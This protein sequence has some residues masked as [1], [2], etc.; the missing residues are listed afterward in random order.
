MLRKRLRIKQLTIGDSQQVRRTPRCRSGGCHMK[1]VLITILMCV[2]VFCYPSWGGQNE[3][4]D[5]AGGLL[6]ILLDVVTAPCS[7]LA[8][9]IGQDAGPCA[10][11]SDQKMQCTPLRE[12]RHHPCVNPA[13]RRS[14]SPVSASKASSVSRS[15]PEKSL[16]SSGTF[17]T[18]KIYPSCKSAC[19]RDNQ[20]SRA[21]KGN[22]CP[23]RS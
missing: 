13:T 22:I 19:C 11:Q 6:D 8:V 10:Y 23:H 20:I 9:C 12:R 21:K 14:A 5:C 18:C 15:E 3:H 17:E 1:K 16:R 4:Q 2:L 7:L